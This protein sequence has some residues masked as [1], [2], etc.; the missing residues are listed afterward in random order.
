LVNSDLVLKLG[1]VVEQFVRIAPN[2]GVVQ[3]QGVKLL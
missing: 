1:A 3:G 2:R